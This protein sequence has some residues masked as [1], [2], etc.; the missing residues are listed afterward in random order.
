MVT[1]CSVR[2]GNNYTYR[3]NVTGQ[4][5]TL[6][7]HAHF[8]LLRVTVYGALIIRPRGGAAAL[9]FSPPDYEANILLGTVSSPSRLHTSKLVAPD[10]LTRPL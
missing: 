9:P 4:E 1:Q 6:W 8:S 7:W 10:D 3:F 2:P 5:G